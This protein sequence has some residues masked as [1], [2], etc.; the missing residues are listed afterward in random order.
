MFDGG[1]AD[2]CR[3][4][5]P[6][7]LVLLPGES[8]TVYGRV[9]EPGITDRSDATDEDAALV[10]QLGWGPRAVEPVGSDRWRW[11]DGRPNPGWNAVAQGEPGND[12]YMAEL[13]AEAFDN[14]HFAWRFSADAGQ[15]WTYCDRARGPGRDGAEDGFSLDDAGTLVVDE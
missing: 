15:T 5:F 9:F 14:F 2:W 1:G 11:V 3:L 4:Q 6:L 7:D 12:E 8:E 10:G 13:Q